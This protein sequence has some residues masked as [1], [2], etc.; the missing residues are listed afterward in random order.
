[1][2]IS[3]LYYI[4]FSLFIVF[5]CTKK[6]QEE[7]SDLEKIKHNN[8]VSYPSTKMDSLQ[9]I[10]SITKQKIQELLDLSAI[11]A[12][13]HKNTDVDSLIYDQINSYFITPDSNKIKPLIS[14]LDSLKVKNIKVKSL[15]IHQKITD[16]DTLDIATFTIEYFGKD[17]KRLGYFDKQASYI[18]KKSPIQ[19]VK[20]FKFYFIDFDLKENTSSEVTK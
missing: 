6:E 19:F 16:K 10:H 12:S 18:L 15:D 20:E 1:M 4:I 11:Y 13:G 9:A 2:K 8:K 3:K 5:S 7:L 14:E 17:K